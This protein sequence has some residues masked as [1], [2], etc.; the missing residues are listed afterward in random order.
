[1][2]NNR[3]PSNND[4]SDREL[5]EFAKMLGADSADDLR[6]KLDNEK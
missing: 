6:R 2:M 5:D 4:A 1:M 3:L